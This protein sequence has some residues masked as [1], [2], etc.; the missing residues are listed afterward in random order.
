MNLRVASQP[1]MA[2][3]TPRIPAS[4]ELPDVRVLLSVAVLVT[5]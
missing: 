3:V 2:P 4:V 1:P 5:Q